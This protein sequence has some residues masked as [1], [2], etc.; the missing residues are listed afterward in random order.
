MNVND[1]SLKKLTT[2]LTN[3]KKKEIT[4][5]PWK[6]GFADSLKSTLAFLRQFENAA[7]FACIT[8]IKD[9][10]VVV[11]PF[12]LYLE[13]LQERAIAKSLDEEQ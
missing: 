10:E 8:K 11:M 4:K 7:R 1:E 13:L 9:K 12:E 3:D 6:H 2:V 5:L